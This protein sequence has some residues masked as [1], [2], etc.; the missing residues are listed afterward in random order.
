MTRGKTTGEVRRKMRERESQKN[1]AVKGMS[2]NDV[3]E[4]QNEPPA[5]IENLMRKQ[6]NKA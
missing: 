4:W 6:K 2:E 5:Y 1:L 3:R